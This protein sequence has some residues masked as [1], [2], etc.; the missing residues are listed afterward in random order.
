MPM[1][2]VVPFLLFTPDLNS[3]T[4][5]YAF[6][7]IISF[8]QSRFSHTFFVFEHLQNYIGLK[9]VMDFTQL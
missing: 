1:S 4:Y 6:M 5:S 8:G 2:L 3:L 9:L 7:R